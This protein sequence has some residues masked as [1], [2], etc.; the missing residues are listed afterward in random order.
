MA[1]TTS[2]DWFL[3]RYGGMDPCDSPLRSPIVVPMAFTTSFASQSFA[4]LGL[5]G[6]GARVWGKGLF[7]G[8]D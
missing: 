3:V 6:W 2:S 1:F 7:R 4:R 8:R 5:R